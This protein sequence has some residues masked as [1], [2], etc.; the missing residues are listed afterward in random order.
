MA[1]IV[2]FGVSLLGPGGGHVLV[3]RWR[4][5]LVWTAAWLACVIAARWTPL[6]LAAGLVIV[7]GAAVDAAVVAPRADW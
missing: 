2:A 3:G 1:R 4:R 6:A 5:G 7:L